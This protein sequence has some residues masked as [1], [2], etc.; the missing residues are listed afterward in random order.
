MFYV[1]PLSHSY[2][3]NDTIRKFDNEDKLNAFLLRLEPSDK[4]MII[5]GE[6]IKWSKK[7]HIELNR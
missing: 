1:I 7:C 5:E 4:I 2:G 6:E 3:I